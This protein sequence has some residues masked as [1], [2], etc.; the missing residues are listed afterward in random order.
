MLPNN[1]HFSPEL[2]KPLGMQEGQRKR[3][4]TIFSRVQLTELEKVFAVTPYPDISIRER[5]AEIIG[6]PEAKIQVWFQNRRARSI[7]SGK[8]SRSSLKR[9]PAKRLPYPGHSNPYHARAPPG[10]QTLYNSRQ[11]PVAGGNY[12]NQFVPEFK[13]HRSSAQQEHSQ[14]APNLSA[15]VQNFLDDGFHFNAQSPAV[16]TQG[17][18]QY[19]NP[20]CSNLNHGRKM[21][22]GATSG[23]QVEVCGKFLVSEQIIPNQQPF[24]EETPEDLRENGP[25][26]SLGS[27]S[28]LIYNAAIVTNLGDS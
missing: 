24:W 15:N 20:F 5:L 16:D 27:I 22:R 7:K 19:F 26:T 4:R 8:L 9:S 3:K 21:D 17:V 23:Y 2:E 13:H 25:Q 10:S 18:S 12:R 11:Y 14:S 1:K 28:D 6:L